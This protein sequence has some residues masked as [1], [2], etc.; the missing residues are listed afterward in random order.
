MT[1]REIIKSVRWCIDEEAIN[2]AS[3]D[4]ASAYD[5]DTDVHT[6]VGLMN[7][8]IRSKIGTAIRWVCLYAPVENLSGAASYRLGL[9]G[10]SI[11]DA[12]EVIQES[13]GLQAV[14]GLIG[15]DPSFI[16]LIRIRGSQWHRA[17]MGD[18]TLREDSEEYLELRNTDGVAATND[19]PQ[20]AIINTKIKSVEVWPSAGNTFTVTY[21]VIPAASSFENLSL[22]TNIGIPP[23][24]ETSFIYYLA[25]LLLSAYGDGRAEQM[26]KI[27]TLNL[28]KSEDKQRQ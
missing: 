26:L 3:L 4:G 28:G 17:I 21:V 9:Q 22:T 16:R 13:T 20:A 15:L 2:A 19:R 25:Y 24:V 7:N 10:Q 27:A 8:I 6:D 14:N 12:I 11:V 5:L 23:L 1:L 18:S